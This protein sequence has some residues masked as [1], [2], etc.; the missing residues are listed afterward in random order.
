MATPASAPPCGSRATTARGFRRGAEIREIFLESRRP[1][2]ERR[3]DVGARTEDAGR[4]H[5]NDGTARRGGLR[6]ARRVQLELA[7]GA[8]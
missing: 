3:F 4:R 8:S 7:G 1:L 5:R 2:P 6:D